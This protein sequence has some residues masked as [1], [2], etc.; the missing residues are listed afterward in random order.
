MLAPRAEQ[1]ALG[2][3]EELSTATFDM[4]YPYVGVIRGVSVQSMSTAWKFRST[5]RNTMLVSQSSQ[6][7]IQALPILKY[8]MQI[9]HAISDLAGAIATWPIAYTV[10]YVAKHVV[11]SRT[12][13][14]LYF[15]RDI[16]GECVNTSYHMAIRRDPDKSLALAHGRFGLQIR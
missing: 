1:I 9:L 6:Q 15:H 4:I 7:K 2:N 13:S 5:G 8:T 10:Y 12:H 11:P 14:L 16:S 3:Q